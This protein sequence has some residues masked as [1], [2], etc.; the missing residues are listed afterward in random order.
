MFPQNDQLLKQYI[1][2]RYNEFL[3]EAEQY[4][5]SKLAIQSNGHKTSL[6]SRVLASLGRKMVSLGERLDQR[7]AAP[8]TSIWVDTKNECYD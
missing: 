1:Q 7:Y 4:R 8:S 3:D 6:T 5:L 2:A